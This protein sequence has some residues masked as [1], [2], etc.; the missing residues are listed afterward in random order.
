VILHGAFA[1]HGDQKG[2]EMATHIA[3]DRQI[4]TTWPQGIANLTHRRRHEPAYVVCGPKSTEFYVAKWNLPAHRTRADCR[5]ENILVFR[6]RGSAPLTKTVGYKSQRSY[7]MPGACTFIPSGEYAHYSVQ[8]DSVFLEL[9]VS[10]RSLETF[11][12]QHNLLSSGVALRPVLA[13]SDPWLAGYCQMLENEIEMQQ[14]SFPALDSLMLGQA[15]QLL[16]AHLVRRY[17]EIK[18]SEWKRF[19]PKEKYSLRPPLLRRVCEYI[20]AHLAK[21]ICLADLAQ[22]AHLSERHFI[23]A[24]KGAT[25]CTP[26][27]YVLDKRLQACAELLR[28]HDELSIA[29]VASAMHFHSRPHFSSKFSE[30]YGSTP[31]EYRTQSR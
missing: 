23:R 3:P 10:P 25:G 28:S 8:G 7:A 20:E 31:T 21:E 29:E 4:A 2:G 26:Y 22:L 9:Y 1:F 11:A 30:R 12:D 16:L 6:R 27:R 15:Q 18:S 19:D 17:S 13:Q 5:M 24:F 14:S